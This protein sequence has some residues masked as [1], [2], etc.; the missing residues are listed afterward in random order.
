[1]AD[2]SPETTI[3]YNVGRRRNVYLPLDLE[4]SSLEVLS[5]LGVLDFQHRPERKSS[6]VIRLLLLLLLVD[7]KGG[8]VC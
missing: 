8:N 3:Y 7:H 5:R 2:T 1:M 4:H 6:I